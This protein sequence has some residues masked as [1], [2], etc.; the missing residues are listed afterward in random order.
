VNVPVLQ[1]VIQYSSQCPSKYH[2]RTLQT[3]VGSKH[4]LVAQL[5]LL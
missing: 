1:S 3:I 4:S 5:K 2:L